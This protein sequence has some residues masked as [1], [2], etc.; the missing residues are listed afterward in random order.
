MR[1]ALAACL[2]VQASNVTYDTRST[3]TAF[4]H[5]EIYFVDGSML[6]LREFVDVETT[7][8]RL[9]YVYQYLAPVQQLVFRY[10]NTGHHRRLNLPTYPHH[11]HEGSSQ[12]QD[13]IRMREFRRRNQDP[14]QGKKPSDCQSGHPHQSTEPTA[15]PLARHA[16]PHSA[17]RL[18]F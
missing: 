11:K 6:H 16:S 10:D 13:D 15:L 1:E 4:I 3:H 14:G 7:P 12:V 17:L 9:A 2:V 8:Y 5:G 18:C